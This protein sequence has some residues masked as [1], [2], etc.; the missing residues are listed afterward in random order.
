MTK[1]RFSIY[2]NFLCVYALIFQGLFIPNM[3]FAEN[4]GGGAKNTASTASEKQSQR[5]CANDPATQWDHSLNRCIIKESSI[6]GREKFFECTDS[7][8]YKTPAA[9]KKCHDDYAKQRAENDGLAGAFVG[10]AWGGTSLNVILAAVMLINSAGKSQ[11]NIQ[12]CIAKKIIKYTAT[13]NVLFEAYYHLM[14]KRGLKNIQKNYE[15]SSLDK[16][17]YQAQVKAFSYIKDEQKEIKKLAD[18]RFKQYLLSTVGYG[19]ASAFA[20]YS[21]SPAGK[22]SQN[23]YLPEATASAETEVSPDANNGPTPK[24]EGALAQ[25]GV[26][27]EALFSN[28]IMI[29]ATTGVMTLYNG[30][31]ASMAK[32]ESNAAS[33][34]S[35]AIDK[36]I[37]KFDG[38]VAGFC[39]SG[40]ENRAEPRCF[41]YNNDGGRNKK[42]SNSETC[43][44]EWAKARQNFFVK[45]QNYQTSKTKNPK[46]CLT[47]DRKFDQK[48]KCRK[49]KNANGQNACFKT[50][51]IANI[52]IPGLA[53][54]TN[55]LGKTIN[56]LTNGSLSPA[57][58]NTQKLLKNSKSLSN[59]RRNLLKSTNKIRSRNGQKPIQL[60]GPRQAL[61]LAKKIATP[62]ARLAASKR[63]LGATSL[64]EQSKNPALQKAIKE[65]SKITG[66]SFSGGRG[67]KRTKTKKRN[68]FQLDFGNTASSRGHGKVQN[69]MKKNY[70]F[71]NNDIVNKNDVSIFQVISNRYNVSGLK[72]LFENDEVERD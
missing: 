23:C 27:L 18:L 63:S 26:K 50:A 52:S 45:A 49:F 21:L 19:A 65:A 39:P 7:E 71:K 16:N 17:S 14:A 25:T 13:S 42:R 15:E 51:P 11:K 37:N 53:S 57:R 35:S 20:I 58:V 41:C 38:S 54:I 2:L 47:L 34:R 43:Q 6:K 67:I 61:R 1:K 4:S 10:V 3:S 9:Q 24:A 68:G 40:R 29:I 8:K 56:S 33:K 46:G 69:F 36:I 66:L 72:R 28:P 32:E 60:L 12:T 64:A 30:W 44:A 70:H 5:E 31:L 55:D 59:L 22:L 48:C 62:K